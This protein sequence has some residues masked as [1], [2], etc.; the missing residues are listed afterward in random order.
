MTTQE[1]NLK[2]DLILLRELANKKHDDNISK[3]I[4]AIIESLHARQD[5]AR[6]HYNLFKNTISNINTDLLKL[7]S[8]F[9]ADDE[10]KKNDTT[11]KANILACIHSIHITHDILAYLIATVLSLDLSEREITFQKVQGKV[12]DFKN[13]KNLLSEFSDSGD[14]KYL[15]SYVNHSKHRYHIEPQITWHFTDNKHYNVQFNSFLFKG[16]KYPSC[17]VEE[18]LNREYNRESRLI[19][20]I[21]NELINILKS[22]QEEN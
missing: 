16:T 6:Y 1:E 2:V 9:K 3:K 17:D 8:A 20:K 4:E 5:F 13:L 7:K 10:A 11:I 21:E 18:F 12:D 14:Y 15:T 22:E 19:I